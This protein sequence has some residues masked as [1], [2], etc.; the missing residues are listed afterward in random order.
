[1]VRSRSRALRPD[2]LRGLLR[3]RRRNPAALIILNGPNPAIKTA[4]RPD[5]FLRVLVHALMMLLAL[6][7]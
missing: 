5:T 1:M 2:F 4:S 7:A 6:S 3:E